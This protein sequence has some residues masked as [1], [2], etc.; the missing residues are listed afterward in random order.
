MTDELDLPKEL[1][2]NAV[3][4][5]L[6]IATYATWP[7]EKIVWANQPKA[8][9][10]MIMPTL[11]QELSSASIKYLFKETLGNKD[12]VVLAKARKASAQLS[13]LVDCDFVITFNWSAWIKLSG[14]QKVALVDHELCH[15]ERDP[16]TW[17]WKSR[18]HDVEEFGEIVKRWG[19]WQQDLQAFRGAIAQ[20]EMF[21]HA[22]ERQV[23]LA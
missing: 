3:E 18:K 1:N 5:A 7:D 19:L 8:I 6:A 20:Y 4:Q 22:T 15:C 21:D 12:H 14:T 23:A 2:R 17:L 16:E 9:A 13:F 10:E 11:H